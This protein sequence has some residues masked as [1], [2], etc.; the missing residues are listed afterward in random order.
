LDDLT[1]NILVMAGCYAYVVAMILV[2]EWLPFPRA[3]SRKFLHAMIGNLPFAMPLF[4]APIYPF[5]VATPFIAVTFLATPY[6]PVKLP[7]RLG[8]L[9]EEG[10]SMGLVMYAVSYAVLAWFFGA[11]PYVVA[12]GILPMAYGDSSAAL[13]GRYLGRNRYRVIEQKSLEGSAAMLVGSF[14]SVMTGLLYF[15]GVYPLGSVS[16]VSTSLAIAV[17]STLV[18]AIAPRGLDNIGVPAIGVLAFIALNGGA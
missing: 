13:V 4:T 14:F 12:A 9:T 10:H 11:K 2:S 7:G 5:L 15:G 1:W 8:G 18:E 3:V 17:L 6:S 16:V